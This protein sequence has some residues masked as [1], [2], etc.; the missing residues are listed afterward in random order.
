MT[1]ENKTETYILTEFFIEILP[2]IV[3][4]LETFYVGWLLGSALNAGRHNLFISLWIEENKVLTTYI[5]A[6]ILAKVFINKL[7][8]LVLS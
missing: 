4:Y 1:K 8:Y 5:D 6:Y 2:H 7:S 3:V